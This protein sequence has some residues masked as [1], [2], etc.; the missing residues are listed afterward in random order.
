VTA[1]VEAKTVDAALVEYTTGLVISTPVDLAYAQDRRGELKQFIKGTKDW[2]SDP[3]KKARAAHKALCDKENETLAPAKKALKIIDAA[4][5][6]H[7][8]REQR[9]RAEEARR[10]EAE[11]QTAEAAALAAQRAEEEAESETDRII[12]Q[13]ET[14][15]ADEALQA[16]ETM[17]AQKEIS[18][19]APVV[20][21]HAE[22]S[23]KPVISWELVD[24]DKVP[25]H[26]LRCEVD[27][28]A[29][30]RIVKA[31]GMDANIPG[32][33]T[34]ESASIRSRPNL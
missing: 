8:V 31:K 24:I 33:I 10:L 21:P 16:A 6:A 5:Q 4:M 34:Q 17:Q 18:N 23:I 1:E 15:A 29:V 20:A 25:R 19:L 13:V 2:F 11:R 26:L 32:I 12:A 30:N 9:K 27:R 3:K 28:N 14:E 22:V 7:V